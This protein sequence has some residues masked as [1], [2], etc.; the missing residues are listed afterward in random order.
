MADMCLMLYAGTDRPVARRK[1][2]KDAPLEFGVSSL[3]DSEESLRRHFRKPEVQNIGSSTCCGC[4]FPSIVRGVDDWP[5]WDG[6][7]E[8]SQIEEES[9]EREALVALLRSSGEPEIELYM[10][11]S[12]NGSDEP[13]AVEE[14]SIE[15]MLE[16]SFRFKEGCFYRVNLGDIAN[17]A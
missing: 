14:L 3:S 6:C 17:A 16:K 5:W 9:A 4:G 11:W 15:A 7:L 8:L 1:W 13:F 2:D 10:I 12:G